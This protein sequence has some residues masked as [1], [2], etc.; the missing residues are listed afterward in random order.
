MKG[1]MWEYY[2]YI[3]CEGAI[4]SPDGKQMLRELCVCCD[5]LKVAG[6]FE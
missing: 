2:F 6:T 3:E 1:L 4:N 5:K